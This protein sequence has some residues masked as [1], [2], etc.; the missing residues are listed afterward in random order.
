MPTR[1]EEKECIPMQSRVWVVC[2]NNPD[3]REHRDA[4]TYYPPTTV[5]TQG[6][7][8]RESE[9]FRT[10]GSP[11]HSGADSTTQGEPCSLFGLPEAR[12][13]I[14]PPCRAFVSIRAVVG[15]GGV[16]PVPYAAGQLPALRSDGGKGAVGAGQGTAHRGVRVAPD[17]LGQAADVAAGG[18]VVSRV[19]GKRVRGGGTRRGMGP[20]TTTPRRNRGDRRGRGAMAAGAPLPDAGVPDRGGVQAFVVCRRRPH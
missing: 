20:G 11:E 13:R 12:S 19:V 4:C 16:F 14:R 10:R 6:V 5:P 2:Q 8:V 9:V 1:L 3:P 15:H 17:V 18:E 7:C